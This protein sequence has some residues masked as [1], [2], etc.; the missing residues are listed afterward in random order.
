M[1]APAGSRA[2][3]STMNTWHPVGLEQVWVLGW[4][5]CCT[6]LQ[7]K[8]FA[9]PIAALE[10]YSPTDKESVSRV[11]AAQSK[12]VQT[13]MPRNRSCSKGCCRLRRHLPPCRCRP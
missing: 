12:Q 1:Q 2:R 11:S 10:C 9:F 5:G 6:L 7:S 3:A 8:M 13:C 4:I